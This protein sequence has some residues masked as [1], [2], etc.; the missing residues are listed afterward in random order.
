M[1]GAENSG[2]TGGPSAE[3]QMACNE[4]EE[5]Q[6]TRM[7]FWHIELIFKTL[8]LIGAGPDKHRKRSGGSGQR[9]PCNQ[10]P[11]ADSAASAERSQ[12]ARAALRLQVKPPQLRRDPPACHDAL[13]KMSRYALARQAGSHMLWPGSAQRAAWQA[14]LGA[15]FSVREHVPYREETC[16]WTFGYELPVRGLRHRRVLSMRLMHWT[17]EKP[18][19][20]AALAWTQDEQYT[21]YPRMC[22]GDDASLQA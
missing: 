10:R 11:Q 4:T 9:R 1:N 21:L 19:I 3:A 2:V 8:H 5:V 7:G 12:Q 13:P 17:F 14:G 22:V 15:V 16:Y 20:K 18:R 6:T